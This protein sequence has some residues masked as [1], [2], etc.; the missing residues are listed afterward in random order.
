VVNVSPLNGTTSLISPAEA[1]RSL[2][3]LEDEGG[4]LVFDGVSGVPQ[5][6]F[7]FGIPQ[8]ATIL[9]E[10]G[11]RLIAEDPELRIRVWSRA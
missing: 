4:D 7:A 9:R 10:R 3:Q 2:D 5:G 11:Y 6:G 8:F 1:D